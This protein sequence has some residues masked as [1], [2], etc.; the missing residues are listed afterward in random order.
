MLLN[1]HDKDISFEGNCVTEGI[2][3]GNKC[4]FI[5]GKLS[6]HSHIVKYAEQ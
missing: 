6:H 2:C 3:R 4:H 5:E 1:I